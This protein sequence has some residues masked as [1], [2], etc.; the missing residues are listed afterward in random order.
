MTDNYKQLATQVPSKRPKC[1][2]LK[3]EIFES[4]PV[5]TLESYSPRIFTCDAP[6]FPESSIR[7]KFPPPVIVYLGPR[8]IMILKAIQVIKSN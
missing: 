4:E 1:F 8:N 5:S 7:K 3:K 2:D 6:V